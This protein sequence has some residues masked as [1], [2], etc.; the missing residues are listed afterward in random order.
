MF[1]EFGF[2]TIK[3][4]QNPIIIAIQL[5]KL[6]FSFKINFAKIKRK[7]GDVINNMVKIFIGIFCSE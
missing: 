5:I 2:K 7:K 3:T 6:S 4:P 1:E